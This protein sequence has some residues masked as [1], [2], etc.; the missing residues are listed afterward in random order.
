MKKIVPWRL[1]VGL[2]SIAY[3]VYMWVRKDVAGVWSTLPREDL[4]PVVLTSVAVSVLKI[5]AIAA[6]VFLARWL[7]SKFSKK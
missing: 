3:I 6:A 5:A 4:L 1:A 2:L 7:I